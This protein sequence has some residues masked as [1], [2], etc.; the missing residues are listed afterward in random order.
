[1]NVGISVHAM[2]HISLM[3]TAGNQKSIGM[4]V[5]LRGI[6]G[7]PLRKF[8]LS[9]R[10]S[11]RRYGRPIDLKTA[12]RQSAGNS[13]GVVEKRPAVPSVRRGL[14]GYARYRTM[15]IRKV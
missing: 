15:H 2:D 13:A 11:Q 4:T 1:M 6:N 8:R 10:G 12:R 3:M 14:V 5:L 7:A 9:R